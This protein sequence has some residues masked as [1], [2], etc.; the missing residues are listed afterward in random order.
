M[1][2]NGALTILCRTLDRENDNRDQTIQTTLKLLK[3]ETIEV[4]FDGEV[5]G[6]TQPSKTYFEGRLVAS[7]DE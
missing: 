7:I 1:Y 4:R 5:Y 6:T 2:L 3:D